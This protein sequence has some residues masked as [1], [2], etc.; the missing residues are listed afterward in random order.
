MKYQVSATE[1]EGRH[2]YLH[3]YKTVSV[4]VSVCGCMC[5]FGVQMMSW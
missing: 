2:F 1:H 3:A 5:P 4:R